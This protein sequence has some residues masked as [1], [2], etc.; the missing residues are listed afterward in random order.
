MINFVVKNGE[1][2]YVQ[3]AKG[4]TPKNS[5]GVVPPSIDK[6]DWPYLQATQS[7]DEFGQ[8]VWNITVD[9]TKKSQALA[10]KSKEEDIANA[11]QTMSDEVDAKLYEV[12]RTKK[13]DYATAEWNTWNDMLN[14]PAAYASAGMKVDHQINNADGVEL[15][16]PG[17]ALDTADKVLAYATRKIQLAQEY[18]VFRVQKLQEFRNQKATIENS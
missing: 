15:F 14:R 1:D 3:P 13:A 7:N 11:Y 6:K 8:P 2:V 10:K 16:S 4:F 9:A 5:I 17:S 12:F 18:G